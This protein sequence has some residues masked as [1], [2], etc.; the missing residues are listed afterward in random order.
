[1]KHLLLLIALTVSLVGFGQ[2]KLGKTQRLSFSDNGKHYTVEFLRDNKVVVKWQN[3][4]YYYVSG[5]KIHHAQGDFSGLLLNGNYIVENKK[6]DLIEKG[7]FKNGLK[8]GLWKKWH[9]N[10]QL[11]ETVRYVKG[12]PVGT[13]KVYNEEGELVNTYKRKDNQWVSSEKLEE[14]VQEEVEEEVIE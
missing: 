9:A 12:I 5:Q 4:K 7:H 11:K 8:S 3:K 2:T 14:P 6:G 10:G 13:K 1:M